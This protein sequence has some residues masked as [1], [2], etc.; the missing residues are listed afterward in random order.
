MV[1]GLC[2]CL[3]LGTLDVVG[4]T[5]DEGPVF[6]EEERVMRGEVA[7]VEVRNVPMQLAQRIAEPMCTRR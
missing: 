5:Q 2:G 7:R 4:S 3:L 1:P 6:Q